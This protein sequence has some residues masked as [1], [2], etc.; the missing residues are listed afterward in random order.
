MTATAEPD[1]ALRE[2]QKALQA[3][4]FATAARI[5]ESLLAERPDSQ[6]ALYMAAV[7]ARERCG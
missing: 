5:A 2:A 4:D 7:S 6:D 3:G 1:Q